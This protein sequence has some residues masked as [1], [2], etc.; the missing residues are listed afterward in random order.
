MRGGRFL[1]A[2]VANTPRLPQAATQ[3]SSSSAGSA[4]RYAWNTRRRS[5]HS[6]L[7]RTQDSRDENGSAAGVMDEGTSTSPQAS[8]S[9]EAPQGS[10]TDVDTATASSQAPSQTMS[11]QQASRLNSLFGLGEDSPASSSSTSE[12]ATRTPFSL[13]ANDSTSSSSNAAS[14]Y[15]GLFDSPD[16]FA[17]TDPPS[18]RSTARRTLPRETLLG[19]SAQRQ[20]FRGSGYDSTSRSDR[21]AAP[22]KLDP[23]EKRKW[24]KLLADV[25]SSFSSDGRGGSGSALDGALGSFARRNDLEDLRQNR[26]RARLGHRATVSDGS[27][28]LARLDEGIG[29]DLS[30]EDIEAG[31]DQARQEMNLQ[32]N[33]ADLWAWAAKEIWAFDEKR[34]RKGS[35]AARQQMQPPAETL[36]E[37]GPEAVA[38]PGE[39]PVLHQAAYGMGTPFYGPVLHQLLIHFRDR[40]KSPTSALAVLQ[41]TRALG[42]RSLV[43]GCTA[44]LYTEAI[45]TRWEEWRDARGCLELLKEARGVGIVDSR[46]ARGLAG[47][48]PN[49]RSLVGVGQSIQG[50]L[51]QSVLAGRAKD[52]EPKT[53]TEIE[54][55]GLAQGA[56]EQSSSPEKEPETDILASLWPSPA[57]ETK[58][59]PLPPPTAIAT[60]TLSLAAMQ[61]LHMADDIGRIIGSDRRRQNDHS[62][63]RGGPERGAGR[64]EE[65]RRG[66]S[67][68][69]RFSSFSSSQS[70]SGDRRTF[71]G[72]SGARGGYQRRDGEA[73]RAWGDAGS[74]RSDTFAHQTPHSSSRGTR[75]NLRR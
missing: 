72:G 67:R 55:G 39:E 19:G 65:D 23:S 34:H 13:S 37:A 68:G 74:G 63:M 15:D 33:E 32:M 16:A 10:N 52:A 26:R 28:R 60:E 43:L 1:S 8:S 75:W 49:S 59:P 54:H 69:G 18:A 61:A 45:R 7:T 21:Y 3:A 50:E 62:N 6:S 47:P 48:E 17:R 12:K 4:T 14:A 58:D 27:G 24:Q 11:D 31:V 71:G 46:I 20:G 30:E 9:S 66:E 40:L 73:R 42:P 44:E 22:A 41:I 2:A 38:A 57:E 29:S 25:A 56:H 70:G 53:G 51:R 36:S 5:F 35:A 64:E